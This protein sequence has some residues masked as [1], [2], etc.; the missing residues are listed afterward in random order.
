V[1]PTPTLFPDAIH[2]ALAADARLNGLRGSWSVDAYAVGPRSFVRC[3]Y[4]LG[5]HETPGMHGE[6]ALRF[7]AHALQRAG[8]SV[9][10]S[11]D[12]RAV[13]V[14]GVADRMPQDLAGFLRR[15]RE[16]RAAI[17]QLRI[18]AVAPR[19]DPKREAAMVSAESQSLSWR[20]E[21]CIRSVPWQE[22]GSVYYLAC[23]A[24][25]SGDR[26]AARMALE[27]MVNAWGAHW[28]RQAREV[29]ARDDARHAGSDKPARW[30]EYDDGRRAA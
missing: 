5:A 26:V 30:V 20:A 10:V 29:L 19:P 11:D 12:G 23:K 14:D 2:A 18:S 27:A 15:G 22:R 6:Q 28:A 25:V 3:A 9:R 17:D 13:M 8:Y 24:L 7:G 4:D 1:A 21:Q 16:D